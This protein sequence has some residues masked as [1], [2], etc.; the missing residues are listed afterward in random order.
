MRIEA[1]EVERFPAA[2]VNFEGEERF[3]FSPG[4]RRFELSDAEAAD[5]RRARDDWRAWEKRLLAMI[6]SPGA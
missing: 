6:G 3:G 2:T 4:W 5:L 1:D